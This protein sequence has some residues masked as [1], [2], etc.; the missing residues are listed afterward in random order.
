VPV[1]QTRSFKFP[2]FKG[3]T[4]R[5]N[6]MK[7]GARSKTGA[8]NIS[9]IPV[10]LRLNQNN[11]AFKG[12]IREILRRGIHLQV[13]AT[14]WAVLEILIQIFAAIRTRYT[15]SDCRVTIFFFEFRYRSFASVTHDKRLSLFDP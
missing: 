6:Q 8:P 15:F 4:Q 2:A 3:E 12:I 7:K 14:I 9:G 13:L 5:F 10:H 11:V 1:I